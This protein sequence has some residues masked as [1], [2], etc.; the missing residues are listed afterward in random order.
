MKHLAH[1]AIALLFQGA[2]WLATGDM[3]AGAAFA[4]AWFVSR[5]HMDRQRQ[6]VSERRKAG[7]REF[8]AMDLLPWEGLD[9][10]RWSTDQR[11]DAA[12]PVL[13]TWLAW[14]LV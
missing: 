6:L 4:T 14:W 9:V 8:D 13:V 12:L 11:L 1:P 2:W 5:E 3:L 7:E 10:W